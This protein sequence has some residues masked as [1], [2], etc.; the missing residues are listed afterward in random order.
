V[1]TT[2]AAVG[3]VVGVGLAVSALVGKAVG[4]RKFHHARRFTS[5]GFL[6]AGIYQLVVGVVLIVY[7][8][9]LIWFFERDP[10]VIRIGSWALICAGVFQFF[11]AMGIIFASALRGAGDT[12]TIMIVHLVLILGLFLPASFAL[13][14]W[15][16]PLIQRDLM[17]LGPWIAGTAY[18][19]LLGVTFWHRWRGTRWQRV[20]IFRGRPDRSE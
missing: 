10:E 1:S 7:R 17:S 20:D 2:H 13:T 18:I 5:C 11:D 15:L 4:E 12:T 6:L 16:M 8:E 19:I 9:E 14:W 3:S